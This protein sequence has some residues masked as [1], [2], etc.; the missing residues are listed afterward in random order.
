MLAIVV[1]LAP[2]IANGQDTDWWDAVEH[3]ATGH[4]ASKVAPKIKTT[5]PT[6]PWSPSTTSTNRPLN[7]ESRPRSTPLSA[8]L[9]LEKAIR[10]GLAINPAVR[11][12]VADANAAGT[13]VDIA[14]W[15]YFP[16]VDL[17]A[18][19]EEFP[20]SEFGYD[21]SARQM[22]YDWGRVDSQVAS[23]DAA[24]R[25]A[26][27][28][29][30]VAEEEAALDIVEV[31]LDVLAAKQRL[32]VT[33]GY[34]D[35]LESLRDLTRDRGSNGYTDSSEQGRVAL[36]LAQARGELA[37]ERGALNDARQQFRVLVG[38]SPGELEAP[39]PSELTARLEETAALDDWIVAAPAYRQAVASAEQAQAELDETQA[40]LK[41]QLNL[42]GSLQRRQ[43][44]GELQDD[45]VIGFRLR[46]DTLQGLANFQRPD[47]ARQRLE[48]ARYRID[49]QQRE[50]RRS[51]LTLIENAEVYRQRQQ[52]LTDQVKE[53]QSVGDLYDDQFS[54]GL[55][56]INDLLTIRQEAFSTRRQLIDLDSQQKRI[57]YR[58]ASQLGLINP[59]ITGR[60][61]DD[62]P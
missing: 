38:V 4:G 20:F 55:R 21:A 59:L 14:E 27:R 2:T 22:L 39:M 7:T 12:A 10:R 8:P 49:D 15:G 50:I 60:L 33:K 45:S 18:G 51:V 61:G 56:D 44:G 53:A 32:E 37:T 36:D 43:I 40:A 16:T 30:G 31:Y 52:A 1:C 28:A 48:A 13:E 29:V 54:V 19:P 9:P 57:Q 23:A 25:E 35:D 24:E 41:P 26:R 17:S 47:A 34:V 58:A 5:L 42:E 6:E 46:M 62:A 11:A 3:E